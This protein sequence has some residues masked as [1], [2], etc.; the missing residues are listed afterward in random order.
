[1]A[2]PANTGQT[3]AYTT[4]KEDLEDVVYKI[5]PTETPVFNL[6]GRGGVFTQR[7]HEWS[8]VE[9]A[10]PN[11][12]NK[13]IE[14]DDVT[15]DAPTVAT[16]LANYA[17]LMDKVC[18]VSSTNERVKSAG[19]VTKMAKQVL[20]KTQEIKRDLETRMLSNSAAAA[21]AAGVAHET[22]GLGAFLK[23]NVS[24]GAGGTNP[25]LSG[26]TSGYPNAGPGNGTQ[27]E[28]TEALLTPVLQAVWEQ[29]GNASHI[30]V[31][32]FNK[33]QASA[34]DGNA[35]RFKRAEDKK[36]IAAIEVY[37]SDFGQLQ[38]VPSR[39]TVTRQAYILDPEFVEVGWL[40]KMQNV[41]IAKLGHSD[42]RMVWCEW[43]LIVGN[44][45]ALGIV[46]DLTTS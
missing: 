2:V 28:F 33:R 10:S 38:I 41:D 20:Y 21:G 17:Q 13:N 14:G 29:G 1:M 11:G 37:E 27:R 39:H 16:R 32:G 4:I 34:F 22:A 30:I 9:L 45:K 42:R 12:D 46:A 44:E 5:T 15:N 19:S 36:L 40:Q 7:L 24:R 8:T 6:V 3:Y 18:G 43:G 25:T 26:G 23:T 35:S 31:G